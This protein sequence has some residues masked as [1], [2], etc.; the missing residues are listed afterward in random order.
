VVAARMV[1][2]GP[3]RSR[4]PACRQ[5]E[6]RFAPPETCPQCGGTDL[7]FLGE[8]TRECNRCG[9]IYIV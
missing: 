9:R 7:L 2:G 5:A 1:M 3:H 8:S 4:K 6:R